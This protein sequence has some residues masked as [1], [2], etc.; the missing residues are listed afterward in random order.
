MKEDLFKEEDEFYCS[1][2][3]ERLVTQDEIAEEICQDCLVYIIHNNHESSGEKW[4]IITKL[5]KNQKNNIP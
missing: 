2:C 5:G 4:L 1:M 3:G